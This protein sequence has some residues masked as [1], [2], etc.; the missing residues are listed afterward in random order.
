MI[1]QTAVLRKAAPGDARGIAHVHVNS[2]RAT[3]RGMVSDEF[4]A[5]LSYESRERMWDRTLNSLDSGAS[6]W[7]VED[8]P[9]NIIG[10]ASA[11][12]SR[13]SNRDYTGEL[14]AIYVLGSHHGRG[15]GRALVEAVAADLAS[16]GVC[17]MFLWVLA[18]NA[19][20]RR[21]YESLGGQAVYTRAIEIGGTMIDEIGYGW[22]DTAILRGAGN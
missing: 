12:A 10:F 7:V 21:F 5:D 22:K 4:L 18:D 17:S 14:Y 15:L 11:G 3:Y 1:T 13:P 19:P 8:G 20:A 9:G 2:W 6:I 16:Q